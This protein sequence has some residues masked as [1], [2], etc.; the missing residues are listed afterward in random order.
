MYNNQNGNQDPYEEEYQEAYDQQGEYAAYAPPYQDP[1]Y[2]EQ[3]G[4]EQP[5]DDP[6]IYQQQAAYTP[7]YGQEGYQE[8]QTYEQPYEEPHEEET[9]YRQQPVYKEAPR[10]PEVVSTNQAVN[11]TCTLAAMMGLFAL[12]LFFYDKR[13]KAVRRMAVQSMTLTIGF[14]AASLGLLILGALLGFIPILGTI[15]VVIFWI[16]FIALLILVVFLKVQMMKH[17][18]NGLAYQ[19]P[20]IG[21]QLRRFE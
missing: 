11:L 17:A 4:Y 19:L 2:Q 16:I 13:S 6:A 15:I 20:V 14:I 3:Q 7:P 18:Y 8:Q 5:Y 10:E 12:F 21:G 1:A 9:T